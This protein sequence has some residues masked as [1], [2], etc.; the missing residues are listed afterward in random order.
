MIL[1]FSEKTK[2]LFFSSE[3]VKHAIKHVKSLV[4]IFS[5]RNFCVMHLHTRHTHRL[6]I[7]D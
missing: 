1:Y 4:F 2:G 7:L 5:V 6:E 3:N